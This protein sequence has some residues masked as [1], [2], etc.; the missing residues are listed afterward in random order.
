MDNMDN[1]DVSIEENKVEQQV[2]D[3]PYIKC[4]GLVRIF[5]S[6]GIEVM[7]LQGLDLEIKKGE[8]MAI[9]GKSGSGKSTLHESAGM[10]G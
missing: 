1:M 5:K 3:E 6:E 2:A 10:S 4:D 9:I 8:L 7:A